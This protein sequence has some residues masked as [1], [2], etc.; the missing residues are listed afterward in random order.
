MEAWIYATGPDSLL[1]RMDDLTIAQSWTWGNRGGVHGPSGFGIAVDGH[2]LMVS[3]FSGPQV[4][5]WGLEANRLR[6]LVAVDDSGPVPAQRATGRGSILY[7]MTWDAV[8]TV[9]L[10]TLAPQ[11]WT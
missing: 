4:Q 3:A 8:Y 2:Q 6:E 5:L 1:A 11:S 9:D 7:L 10:R